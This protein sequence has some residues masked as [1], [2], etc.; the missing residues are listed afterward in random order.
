MFFHEPHEPHE[1]LSPVGR[2][3]Q[4]PSSVLGRSIAVRDASRLLA[5]RGV[6]G[7]L[8][9]PP[10]AQA[11]LLHGV[12]LAHRRTAWFPGERPMRPGLFH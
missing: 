10:F 1:R 12:L 8:R 11:S 6:P 9:R 7:E 3:W 4:T 2:L 5:R